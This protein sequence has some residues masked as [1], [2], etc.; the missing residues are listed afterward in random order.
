VPRLGRLPIDKHPTRSI[1]EPVAKGDSYFPTVV[2]D[3]VALA[4][5]HKQ[6]GSVVWPT[7]QEALSLN[8]LGLV[9]R[10]GCRVGDERSR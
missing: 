3:A 4:Y 10:P 8:N 9:C 7:M 6:A 5:G 2:Y 1:Y